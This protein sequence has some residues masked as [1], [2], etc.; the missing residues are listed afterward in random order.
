VAEK[1]I[2]EAGFVE[3]DGA[4]G[5]GDVLEV[6]REIVD[7]DGLADDAA[8]LADAGVGEF[9][10]DGIESEEESGGLAAGGD[11]GG[12][13]AA[14]SLNTV[15]ALEAADVAVVH[16][17]EWMVDGRTGKRAS[18]RSF[19]RKL[20]GRV[21]LGSCKLHATGN[22][23]LARQF[24]PVDTPPAGAISHMTIIRSFSTIRAAI[25]SE[26]H[27]LWID[28]A[29]T[30]DRSRMDFGSK[31]HGLWVEVAWTLDRS[32]MDFGSRSHGLWIK[33]HGLWIVSQGLWI[34]SHGF[35]SWSHGLWIVVAQA[36]DR[37]RMGFGS[38]SHGLWVVVART[39]DRGRMDFGAR[40]HRLRMAT[41][42]HWKV[43]ARGRWGGAD[44]GGMNPAVGC[45]GVVAHGDP[46]VSGTPFRVRNGRKPGPGVVV[47]AAPRPRASHLRSL[48]GSRE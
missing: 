48:P 12:I 2:V 45:R 9:E 16:G 11:V 37:G 43:R 38:W 17:G 29:W 20:A 44:S 26:A 6:E 33:S 7:E 47:A 3:L 8:E 19:D 34:V 46:D 24:G 27:A 35:G 36:L 13:V 40:L 18:P 1:R 22:K 4:G 14:E 30:L 23:G 25:S 15:G 42:V 31:S 32:R 28:L 41:E 10:D 21:A 39:L 5:A